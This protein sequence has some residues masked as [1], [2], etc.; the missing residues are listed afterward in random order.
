M[1]SESNTKR[2]IIEERL[3]FFIEVVI[4][5]LGV[6]IILMLIPSSVYQFITSENAVFLG[7]LFYFLKAIVFLIALPLMLYLSNYLME[8]QDEGKPE[9]KTK[10]LNKNP[11]KL[12]SVKK[13]KRQVSTTIWSTSSIFI[14]HTFRL[15]YLFNT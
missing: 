15:F 3:Y 9:L 1:D 6:G 13:K 10:D 2:K 11:L 5:F 14:F 7:P 12:F 4:V 8:F